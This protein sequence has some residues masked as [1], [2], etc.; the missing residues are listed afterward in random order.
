MLYK[1][2][3][4]SEK[5]PLNKYWEM[6]IGSCHA[7]TALRED[8]RRQLS[9][10]HRDLGFKYVRFH[11]LFDDDMS[12]IRQSIFDGAKKISFAN[13]DNIFDF[14]LSINM[15]PFVELSFMPQCMA[16]GDQT[17]FHYK[18]NVTPPADI[19]EWNNF[20]ITF[21]R[22]LIERY[23]RSEVRSWF[24]EVW[25][26]PNLGKEGGFKGAQFWSASMD[27]YYEF[28]KNTAISIKNVDSFL[29]VGGPATSNNSHI[30]DMVEY[31]KKN[32]VPL[33]FIS[34]HH[35]PT[36]VVLGYG[37][38]NSR[39]FVE[40][41]NSS[42][43]SDSGI[44]NQFVEEFVTFRKDIWKDVGRGVLTDMAKRAKKE[45]GELP[46]YYTEW[47]SLAG[48]ESDGA[49][50]SS[51]IAKTVMDNHGIPDGYAY[52]TFS[53]IL[54]EDGF[55][56]S[57]FHGGY[58]LMT[59][60]GIPKAPYRA[61]Q[62]LHMLGDKL[63]VKKFSERTVDIYATFDSNIN[64]VKILAVNHQSLLHEIHNETISIELCGLHFENCST[65]II[66]ID[67][68]HANALQKW[69]ELG[70]VEYATERQLTEML[71]SSYLAREQQEYR[72]KNERLTMNL[73]LPAMGTALITVYLE[74][75]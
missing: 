62:L 74:K 66:K 48:L 24:F 30:T 55:P 67:D 57:E 54:E 12:V 75:E 27:D 61:F 32:R 72:L 38:E 1:L 20:I 2:D 36:D 52:W 10:C 51:F 73:T 17:I 11:G 39:N 40:K 45:A 22:H 64:A 63:Y 6:C 49:F 69:R 5:I 8:Y 43:L 21:V 33:D 56:S 15:K 70:N 29:R 9:A 25:N 41:F 31:C 35:Y 23:G 19:K 4:K 58:G 16:S 28:Y 37:A 14:L 3:L 18:G 44:M 68:N 59:M 42:D 13:I 7:A 65:E 46:L 34:T 47:S 71:S 50:G 26:E 53:D 60:H